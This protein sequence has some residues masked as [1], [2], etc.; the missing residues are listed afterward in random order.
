LVELQMPLD[1]GTLYAYE[2]C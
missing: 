2:S 1:Q